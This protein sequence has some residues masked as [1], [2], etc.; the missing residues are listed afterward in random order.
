[1]NI[2]PGKDKEDKIKESIKEFKLGQMTEDGEPVVSPNQALFLAIDRANK[3]ASKK[4]VKKDEL[5]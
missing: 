5:P 1:M 2:R 4:K 3:K